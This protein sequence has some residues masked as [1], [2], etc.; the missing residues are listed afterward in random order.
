MRTAAILALGFVAVFLVSLLVAPGSEGPP[1]SSTRSCGS[2]VASGRHQ[3]RY[4]AYATQT[5]CARAQ[6]IARAYTAGHT[7]RR[8]S[9]CKAVVAGLHCLTAGSAGPGLGWVGCGRTKH[10]RKPRVFFSVKHPGPAAEGP[11]GPA[12]PS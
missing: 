5:D 7:C 2:Y 3:R 4:V 1:V 10:I 12:L 9:D 8:G 6:R 11:N